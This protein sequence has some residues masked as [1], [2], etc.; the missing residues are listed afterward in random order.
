MSRCESGFWRES[1]IN[2]LGIDEPLAAL[3]GVCMIPFGLLGHGGLN[4]DPAQ[5]LQLCLVRSSLIFVGLGTVA[6]HVIN[7]AQYAGY[8]NR[9]LYDAMTMAVLTGS[10]FSL[11][12]NDW[13]KR[14]AMI[15]VSLALSFIYMW[16]VLNDWGLNQRLDNDLES[17]QTSIASTAL[18]PVFLLFCGYILGRIVYYYGLAMT[19]RA[20]YPMWLALGVAVV[21]WV[22]YEFACGAAKSLFF[23]HSFWHVAIAYTVMYAALLGVCMQFGESFE[24][25]PGGSVWWPQLRGT[26]RDAQDDS[27]PLLGRIRVCM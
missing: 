11:F 7:D 1:G 15:A 9:K 8:A 27:M 16:I 21:S 12:W 2:V 14:H 26:K 10:L 17:R 4:A 22:V 13:L 6:Y 18:F 20:H 25:V 3:S 24:L 5:P 23:F 19:L